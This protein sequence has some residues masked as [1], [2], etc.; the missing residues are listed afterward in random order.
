MRIVTQT[1]VGAFLEAVEEDYFDK[2]KLIAAMAEW[3]GGQELREMIEHHD[4]FVPGINE[5]DL[6]EQ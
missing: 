2:D 5:P 4:W 6:E 3:L 1:T